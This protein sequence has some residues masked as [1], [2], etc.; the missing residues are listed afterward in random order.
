MRLAAT[1]ISAVAIVELPRNE[2]PDLIENM[3]E[4]SSH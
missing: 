1:C 3:V 2:W 4:N